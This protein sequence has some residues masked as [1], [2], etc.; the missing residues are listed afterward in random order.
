M[1]SIRS[2]LA[3]LVAMALAAQL[4]LAAEPAQLSVIVFDGD[5]PA[6]DVTLEVDGRPATRTNA[7][8]AA[9]ATLPAGEHTLV[10]K[11]GDTELLSYPLAVVEGENDELIVTLEADGAAD[12]A[13]ESSHQGKVVG[14]ATPQ[15]AA[16]PPGSIVGRILDSETRKP[17][18]GARVFVSGTRVD[19]R[20]N[21]NGE[22]TI[23]LAPGSY[24]VSV[25]AAD[26][27]TQTI[28]LVEVRSEQETGKNIE[29]TPS[30]LNLPEYIVLEPYVEGSLAAFVEE[31]RTTAAVV[32]ILGAEQIARA[33]DSDAAGALKRVTGLTLVDGKYV[34]VRGLGERYSSVLLNGAS[35][36]SPD[37]TRRVVP[38]D[39]FPTD[40]LQGVVIQKTYSPEMPGE[41]G[42]G[43]IQLRTKAV[44][45][46]FLLRLS[47]GL[48]YAQGTTFEDGLTYA[49]GEDW[50]GKDDGARRLPDSIAEAIADGR[51]IRPQTPLNP[52]GFTQQQIERFGED[53]SGTYDI[54]RESV[55]P[56][57]GL[58]GSLGNT[59]S[60]RDDIKLGFLT[61]FRYADEWDSTEETRRN[62]QATDSGLQLRDE[63]ALE[64]TQRNIDF[65]GFLTLGA[66]LGENHRLKAN[67][68]LV[69]Q[70]E[71][72]ARIASGSADNQLLERY[73]LQWVENALLANQ[74]AGEHAFPALGN[75]GVDW[76]YTT[77]EA[78]RYEPNTR[79]YRYDLDDEGSRRFSQL[80]DSNSTIYG[81]LD[82]SSESWE[83][84]LQY[85]IALTDKS[86]LKLYAGAGD[87]NRER[88]SSIR[89][90]TFVP[91]SGLDP[92]I[93]LLPSLEEILSD[94]NIRANGFVF[95]EVT[96]PTDNYSAG[97]QLEHRFLNADLNLFD[98]FR[99]VLGAR[100]EQ[101]VQAVTTFSVSNPNAPPVVA[102]LDEGNL[103]PSLAFTWWI[104]QDSQLRL[105]Y[106]ETVSRP[107]FRE[108]S[109]APYLDPILDAIAIGNPD[110]VTTEIA[111]Y[112]IRYEY[113][114]SPSETVSLALFQKEFTN[115]IEKQRLPGVGTLLE[116]VNAD[117]ATN[118]GIEFDVHKQLGF[119]ARI[120]WL[121]RLVARWTDW[122]N[123]Y[124][125]ANYSYIESEIQLDPD[126]S[127]FVTNL[128]RPLE[129]QSPYVA[130]LQLGYLHPDGRREVALL[131]NSFGERIV[132]VGVQG[133]P[134]I[135][136]QPFQQLDL[137]WTEKLGRDWRVRL[138]LR[139]I[140]DDEVLFT[141]GPETTREYQ[142]GRE[143]SIAVEWRPQ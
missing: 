42:G 46:S 104:N 87:L 52:S 35:I 86:S 112:D 79:T 118:R 125:A 119:V 111:N 137:V 124:V 68:V 32:D 41:F 95:T 122:E 105:A 138:R 39:L 84:A 108:L 73:S 70:T 5:A 29:L 47:L 74:V 115:P 66:E 116:L 89:R 8:G 34:Y 65:S 90:F 25:V 106:S 99:F 96:S 97:Q 117:G 135:Y 59:W 38:L 77:A 126:Q 53:L 121:G 9:Y 58:A 57:L 120:P 33:G 133:Q 113:Y 69:R 7:D 83:V 109:E 23:V 17:V 12:V 103:L 94:A 27:S 114:F 44:P 36:P 14:A 76:L 21:E 2:S 56:N 60:V 92:A 54:D 16:G 64:S 88:E 22:Y 48:G 93:F 140:L 123:Y 13:L 67:S 26:Y 19:A 37:P 40:I 63:I 45:E 31:R 49:G 129:G 102:L 136:E 85:P 127:Q 30:G 78:S 55:Q 80:A 28:E 50:T 15:T 110:L 10:L 91:R 143:L 131:Y 81:D 61:S 43:T 98:R 75:L 62:F 51:F 6:S 100:E 142:K 3:A 1:P 20:T 130:N 139:N 18:I 82:D 128:N 72:E 101:N 11:R 141:Q 24:S 132:N 107:D 71:D 4:A 134:D